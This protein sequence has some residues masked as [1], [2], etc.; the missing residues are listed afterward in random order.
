MPIGRGVKSNSG[1]VHNRTE[2]RL[3]PVE[4]PSSTCLIFVRPLKSAM[5][6]LDALFLPTAT[7][8][9][10]D[11]AMAEQALGCIDVST[12]AFNQRDLRGR[13]ALLHFPHIILLAEK[14]GICDAD[15][16]LENENQLNREV[17]K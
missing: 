5:T 14:R 10:F 11:A 2:A 8:A 15:G 12:Q 9:F 4:R 7:E 16:F 3:S 17:A 6:D 1:D 13:D